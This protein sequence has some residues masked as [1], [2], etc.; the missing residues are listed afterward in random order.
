MS[1][2]SR[3]LRVPSYWR[4]KPSGQA[5]VT[6][7]GQDI[8]LGKWNTKASRNSYNQLVGEW[9]ASDGQLPPPP[10]TAL[11]VSEFLR[12]YFVA[13]T[14][15]ETVLNNEE[16]LRREF[17]QALKTDQPDLALSVHIGSPSNYFEHGP[18]N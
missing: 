6:I 7:C 5:V 16:H 14:Y 18:I 9:L 10:D 8:Y 15:L 12:A 13:F 3:E 4:H 2:F 17:D 11:T 1:D